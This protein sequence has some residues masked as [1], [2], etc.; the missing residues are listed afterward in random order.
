MS[1]D[2]LKSRI[3]EALTEPSPRDSLRRLL[4]RHGET[5]QDVAQNEPSTSVHAILENVKDPILT[6]DEGGAV[7][8]ANAAATRVFAA[9]AAEL[10]ERSVEQLIPD[11][12]ASGQTLDGLADRVGDTFVDVLPT[13]IE[14]RRVDGSLFKAEVTVSRSARRARSLLRDVPARYHRASPGRAGAARER[15][16]LPNARRECARGHRRAR[17]RSAALRR[18]ERERGA[19]LQAHAREAARGWPAR[20]QPRAAVGRLAFVRSRT[21][22]RRSRAERRQARVRMAASGRGG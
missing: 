16:A 22:L 14:A 20:D 12:A 19:A 18:R 4:S 5:P 17:R 15:G 11:L 10:A 2:R 13:V 9:T 21:R 8:S 3:A 7:L 6:V 1:K